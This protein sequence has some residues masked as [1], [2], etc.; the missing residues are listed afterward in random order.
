MWAPITG[1]C[2]NSHHNGRRRSYQECVI[3]DSNAMIRPS[4]LGKWVCP[5]ASQ[6]SQS[7]KSP[8]DFGV[9]VFCM[10]GAEAETNPD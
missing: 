1:S 2:E 4:T 6:T 3:T 7:V 9:T 8:S 10:F 5:Q